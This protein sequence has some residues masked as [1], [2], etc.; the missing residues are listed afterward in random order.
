M[1]TGTSWRMRAGLLAA[2]LFAVA[3]P[4]RAQRTGDGFLFGAPTGSFV[5]RGGFDQALAGSDLF[6]QTISDFTLRKRDFGGFDFTAELTASLSPRWDLVFGAGWSGSS[7]ASEY[8]HW[9]DNSSQP[10]QQ[11]T[12]FQRVPLMVGGRFHLIP[13][14]ERIG[15]LAWVPSRIAPFVGAGLGA[16]WYRFRQ[17]GDFID[18]ASDS[19]TVFTDDLSSAD[20]ALAAYAEAGVDIT[21]TPRLFL[22]GEGRYTWSRGH[23]GADYS[24]FGRMDLSGVAVTVGVGFRM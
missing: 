18:F 21:L 3:Q 9:V 10:I 8:R 13:A 22:T 16:T 4:A 11:T 19:N 1:R 17:Y 7:H 2:G 24:G 12:S 20:W 5:V 15:H 14:G 23:V 6:A